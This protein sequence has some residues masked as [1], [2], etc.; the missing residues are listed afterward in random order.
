MNTIQQRIIHVH[1]NYLC[2]TFHLL[3]CNT[4]RFFIFIIPY[5]ACKL[6]TAGYICTFTNINKV[7]FRTND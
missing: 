7:C 1:I 3:P 5:K 6:F 2:A 4:Q